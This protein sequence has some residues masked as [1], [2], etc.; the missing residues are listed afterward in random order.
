MAQRPH[1]L[2]LR[3]RVCMGAV[4]TPLEAG[5]A[6]VQMTPRASATEHWSIN[7]AQNYWRDGDKG[8]VT[9]TEC[10]KLIQQVGYTRGDMQW[11]SS[12]PNSVAMLDKT[13]ARDN[14]LPPT[15]TVVSTESHPSHY[16]ARTSTT[17]R[18]LSVCLSLSSFIS[19]LVKCS[20]RSAARWTSFT[21]ASAAISSYF[22]AI[23]SLP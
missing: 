13:E 3:C 2:P 10:A 14:L 17:A 15:C 18:R 7:I 9:I 1:T 20:F 11:T 21:N 8:R 19:F 5:M 12:P 4:V 23:L 6:S 22:T 16:H